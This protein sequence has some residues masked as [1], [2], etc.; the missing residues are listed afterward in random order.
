MITLSCI[1]NILKYD[2]IIF[3]KYFC[4][5][6][7]NFKTIIIIIKIIYSH[8]FHICVHFSFELC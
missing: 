3:F 8:I 7:V 5:L 2:L 4:I 6:L 1:N